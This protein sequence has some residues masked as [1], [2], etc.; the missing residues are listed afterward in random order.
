MCLTSAPSSSGRTRSRSP[1]VRPVTIQTLSRSTSGRRST[2]RNSDRPDFVY[3]D[4]IQSPR[5]SYRSI[6]LRDARPSTSVPTI[7]TL[8]P[9]VDIQTA[10]P[11]IE[12]RAKDAGIKIEAPPPPRTKSIPSISR[13]TSTTPAAPKIRVP[14]AQPPPL[15]PDVPIK[16]ST[17]TP[18][19]NSHVRAA[20]ATI[21][22]TPR[23]KISKS[24]YS[25]E[26]AAAFT[27]SGS[28]SSRS[29][30][31]PLTPSACQG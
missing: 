31:S 9:S 27:S 17:T 18:P 20:S 23:E 12:A 24:A 15:A 22:R 13:R 1:A 8:R 29:P 11:S 19:K 7:N 21:P 10:R 4:E 14:A 5:S 2:K 6:R 3:I 30:Q 25:D 28:K 26:V 16:T